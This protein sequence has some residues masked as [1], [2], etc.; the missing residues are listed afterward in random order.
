MTSA[1]W[2][3][4]L[5]I[6]FYTANSS[7]PMTRD[8]VKKGLMVE[9]TGPQEGVATLGPDVGSAFKGKVGQIVYGI[10]EDIFCYPDNPEL[11]LVWVAFPGDK[12]PRRQVSLAW[13]EPAGPSHWT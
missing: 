2:S 11:D 4:S 12:H 8:N 9:F 5:D 1:P 6:A 10:S 3:R 7:A 13:L